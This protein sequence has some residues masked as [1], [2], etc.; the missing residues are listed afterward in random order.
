MKLISG[1][2]N[3]KLAEKIAK[4]LNMSLSDAEISTF[5]DGETRINLNENFRGEDVFVIQSISK[6]ANEHLMEM[7]ICIDALKRSSAKRITAV[8]PYFGYARQDSKPAPRTPITAK[9][10]SN[11]ITT[12]GADRVCTLDLHARQ[13][14]GFFDIPCDNLTSKPLI[15]NHIKNNYSDNNIVIVSPDVGGVTRAR[16][17]AE[18]L[19]TTIAIIDKRRATANVSE[20]MNVIG[21][22]EGKNCIIVDDIIDTAGTLLNASKALIEKGALS[23]V[24]YGTHGVLS[25][26]ALENINKSPYLS[27]LFVTESINQENILYKTDKI[28]TI[29][30][31]ELF[32]EAIKRINEEKSVSILFD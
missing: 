30:I 10:I 1:N 11:L 32:G 31:A 6:P 12:S 14:Q 22:I 5:S 29:S 20:V 18:N 16:G 17:I 24:A 8:V 4:Y 7:L 23:V 9:L 15:T 2:S 27:K 28:K 26:P 19:E 21:D 25:G 13:I 3:K